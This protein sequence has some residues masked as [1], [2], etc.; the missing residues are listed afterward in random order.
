MK[1]LSIAV[2][3]TAVVTIS[4]VAMPVAAADIAAGAAK[5]RE[6]CASCHGLNGDSPLPE[7]P[8]IGGQHADF[9][10]KA[11]RDY[12]S[13]ARKNPVMAGFAAGLTA[14]DMDNLAAYYASQPRRLRSEY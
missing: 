11:L 4:T 6:V 13:G 5:A 3:L 7:N 12:K 9:L 2:L 14:Q 10:A 1:P 8:K